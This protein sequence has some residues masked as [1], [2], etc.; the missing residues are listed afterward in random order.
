[1]YSL[2][3]DWERRDD[4]KYFVYGVFFL[5]S[6]NGNGKQDIL[7][8]PT[9]LVALVTDRG[10]VT[11][12]YYNTLSAARHWIKVQY[13]WSLYFPL[14]FFTIMISLYNHYRKPVA[15]MVH[16]VDELSYVLC[17]LD[18]KFLCIL[19]LSLWMD[20]IGQPAFRQ[21]TH[22]FFHN[23]LVILLVCCANPMPWMKYLAWLLPWPYNLLKGHA[24]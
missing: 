5:W 11:I 18:P 10:S 13:S 8:V 20:R 6:C 21:L 1:M 7:L 23:L 2:Y 24:T 16:P 4:Y 19:M 14:C 3:N 17:T 22:V 12:I 9:S 15:F